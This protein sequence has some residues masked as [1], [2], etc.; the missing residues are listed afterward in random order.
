MRRFCGCYKGTRSVPATAKLW[1]RKNLQRA[2]AQLGF[3]VARAA[4]RRRSAYSPVMRSAIS[5]VLCAILARLLHFR[6]VLRYAQKAAAKAAAL[7]GQKNAIDLYQGRLWG[8]NPQAEK[9]PP[10]GKFWAF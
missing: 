9:C 3:F 8:C 10:G 4:D 5:D 6:Y 2:L 7:Q 1:R